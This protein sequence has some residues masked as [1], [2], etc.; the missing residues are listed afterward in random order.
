MTAETRLFKCLSDNFG[1]LL[2][3]PKTGATASIDAPEAA[4]VER[5]LK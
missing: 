3:D 2:H 4:A 5:A 1:V